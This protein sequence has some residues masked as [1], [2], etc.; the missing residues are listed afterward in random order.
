MLTDVERARFI[1]ASEIVLVGDGVD[2]GIGTLAERSLHRIL[3]LYTD[4]CR[5]NHE[6]SYLGYVVDVMN[7]DGITEV[8]TRDFSRLLP[9]LMTFLAETRVTVIYPITRIRTLVWLDPETGEASKPRRSPR[10]GRPS[11]ALA[12]LSRLLPVIGHDRLTVRLL[13]IDTEDYKEQNGRGRDRKHYATRYERLPTELVDII[14]LKTRDDYR[15]LIPEGLSDGFTAAEFDR[16][17]ALRGRRAYFSLKF[18][19]DLGLLTRE[20]DGRVYRYYRTEANK[21]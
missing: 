16:A 15:A 3:K 9:K 11:D 7:S 18:L 10:R 1:E 4:P 5:E 21:K 13:L 19:L 20:K 6:V 2:C 14:E 8:Q 12:E 17:A